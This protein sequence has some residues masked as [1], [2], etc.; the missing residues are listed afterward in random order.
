MSGLTLDHATLAVA[1][2]ATLLLVAA[3][4]FYVATDSPA[5]AIARHWGRSCLAMALGLVL[6]ASA[7]LF[8]AGI[9]AMLGDL[10]FSGALVLQAFALAQLSRL[11]DR[12]SRIL[13]VIACSHVVLAAQFSLVDPSPVLRETG[14]LA[15][16]AAGL[17]TL[18]LCGR[19]PLRPELTRMVR[20]LAGAY[21]VGGLL[22]A[23]MAIGRWN[24]GSFADAEHASWAAFAAILLHIVVPLA[25]LVHSYR[26]LAHRL[27]R[28][29]TL[30]PLT[31]AV[32]RRG[33]GDA[34]HL[35]QARA[36][37]GD[38]GWHVGVVM[39]DIDDFKAVNQKHGFAVGDTVLQI[40][41]DAM[42][43]VAR[44][45]DTVSRFGGEE[46]CM[47][48][49]GVTIRQAQVVTDRIRKQVADQAR[50][51]A[52][53]TI[54]VSAGITVANASETALDKAIDAADQMLYTAK[55]DG[56]DRLRVDPDALRVIAGM[57]PARRSGKADELGF[58]LV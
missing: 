34:W 17:L 50:E 55:R 22:Y 41:V 38:D 37:R 3:A 46:F 27:N 51:R 8:P 15:L 10:V 9:G 2:S 45:Y 42:R 20:M 35:L 5:P 33:L 48:L 43:G 16:L 4:F 44:R 25:L 31:Q 40:V 7:S 24:I 52:G 26:Q 29:A 18:A 36:R 49:P 14:S 39:I 32:N 56:R 47:L 11:S 57:G 54:T 28:S 13:V 12:I 53:I 21:I 19:E 30:D 58:P 6:K 1:S 23:A